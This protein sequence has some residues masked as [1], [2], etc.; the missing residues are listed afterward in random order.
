MEDRIEK[1]R[2][3]FERQVTALARQPSTSLCTAITKV[4]LRNGLTCHVE[5]GPWKLTVDM[6]KKSGGD[7]RGPDPGV[8]G[9]SAFGIVPRRWLHDVGRTPRCCVHQPRG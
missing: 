8:L 9:R 2:M 4:R 1:I 3:A 7:S 6:A 5:D